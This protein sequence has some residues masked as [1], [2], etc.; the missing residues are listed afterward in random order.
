MVTK[1]YNIGAFYEFLAV[2]SRLWRL[3]FQVLVVAA[4]LG[5]GSTLIL[6]VRQQLVLDDA[7]A[8]TNTHAKAIDALDTLTF[9][10]FV[11]G[12]YKDQRAE[13]EDYFY[14]TFLLLTLGLVC[15]RQAI[16]W[17]TNRS[18]CTYNKLQK[19]IELDLRKQA[20]SEDW[21]VRAPKY[22]I[23]RYAEHY[24]LHDFEDL[25]AR[26]QESE[27]DSTGKRKAAKRSSAGEVRDFVPHNVAV[28]IKAVITFSV[29]LAG[30]CPDLKIDDE[31]RATLDAWDLAHEQKRKKEHTWKLRSQQKAVE[32]A[33]D[34]EGAAAARVDEQDEVTMDGGAAVKQKAYED[35]KILRDFKIESLGAIL[36]RGVDR[37]YK[38][39]FFKGV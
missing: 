8:G 11:S 20:D 21:P 24:F 15:E 9:W 14:L 6:K 16:N 32:A 35:V 4:C 36:Q 29:K 13:A 22:D 37:K 7:H 10:V 31:T 26:F 28:R 12:I 18:G 3:E 34:N 38:I 1:R 25:K 5:F 2:R 19:F 33:A 39:S 23:G 17:L 27:K 30:R